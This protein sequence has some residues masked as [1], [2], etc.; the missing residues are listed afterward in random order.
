ML[1]EFWTMIE[2]VR[3]GYFASMQDFKNRFI[4]PIQNGQYADSTPTDVR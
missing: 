2:F 4:L 1:K 3:P